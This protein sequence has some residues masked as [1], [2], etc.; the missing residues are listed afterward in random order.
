MRLPSLSKPWLK[1][2]WYTLLL[3]AVIATGAFY[4]KWSHRLNLTILD[5]R[6]FDS[7]LWKSD[8]DSR[9]YMAVDLVDNHLRKGMSREKVFSLIGRDAD[10]GPDDIVD[11]LCSASMMQACWLIIQ[12]DSE[13][14]LKDASIRTF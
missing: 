8:P 2:G 11:R 10:I 13:G 14:K 9:R 1:I 4:L 5:D 3:V 7:Q 6:E 12:F